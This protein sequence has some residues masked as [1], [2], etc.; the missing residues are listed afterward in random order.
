M[1]EHDFGFAGLTWDSSP[2]ETK[3]MKPWIQ[4]LAIA[5]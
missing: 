3:L 1:E 5:R 2:T 4:F